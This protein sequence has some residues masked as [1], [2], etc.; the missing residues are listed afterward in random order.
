MRDLIALYEESNKLIS[1]NPNLTT[2]K[3]SD[4]LLEA[5]LSDE[6][7][8]AI[9]TFQQPFS[10]I[11]FEL[12]HDAYMRHKGITSEPTPETLCNRF[13]AFLCILAHE[14]I[15]RRLPIKLKSVQIFDFEAYGT[16]L[17]FD[18]KQQDVDKFVTLAERL[19]PLK[20]NFK[21]N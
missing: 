10:L 2:D 20:N 17:V 3:I 18:L 16:P 12:G 15:N 8:T 13:N 11:V 6:K 7:V 1:S 4:H 9:P 19:K 14:F 5:W 21:I